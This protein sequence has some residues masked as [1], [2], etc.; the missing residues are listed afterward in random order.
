M[1]DYVYQSPSHKEE[2]VKKFILLIL[3][4]MIGFMVIG[5]MATMSPE[6]RSMPA[7]NMPPPP[8][9]YNPSCMSSYSSC[10]IPPLR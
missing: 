5:C 6:Q 1:V 8:E 10:P 2:T 9:V 7:G 3:F 4:F